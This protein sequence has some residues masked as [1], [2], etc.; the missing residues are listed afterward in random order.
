[1]FAA[2]SNRNPVED[3]I[4]SDLREW[5]P[6]NALVYLALEAV[7]AS[8]E[9]RKSGL[10][11]NGPMLMTLLAYAYATGLAASR[12]I[13]LAIPQDRTLRYLCRSAAPEWNALRQFRRRHDALLKECL[14][15]LLSLAWAAKE[16]M[17]SGEAQAP[18]YLDLS[19]APQMTSARRLRCA[20]EA[21]LR[22]EAAVLAASLALDD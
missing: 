1:M 8:V 9:D 5:M 3:F 18:I 6:E 19:C 12:D 14:T 4:P 2:N 22:L 16:Q 7:Q 20:N 13:E 11:Q 21:E 15:T 17:E 10:P